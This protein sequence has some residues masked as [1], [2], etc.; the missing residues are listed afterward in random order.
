M[1][2]DLRLYVTFLKESPKE[3][4][5][6]PWK[7]QDGAFQMLEINDRMIFSILDVSVSKTTDAMNVLEKNFGKEITTRNWNTLLKIVA[8]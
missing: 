8:L 1:H 3:E 4:F 7:S 5:P 6:L 2:K